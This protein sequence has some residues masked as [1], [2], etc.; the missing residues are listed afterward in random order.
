MN[1]LAKPPRERLRILI[2]GYIVR[3]PLGGM[4]WH[5]LQY[6]MSLHNLGHE[7]Y[8]LEDSDDTPFCCY[9]PM[10][11]VTDS[12]PTYGLKFAAD[13]LK[14][15]GLGD[16]WAYYDAHT[17][18]W[19]GPLA[20]GIL[21]LC[22]SADLLLNVSMANP[23]RPWLMEIPVRVAI[24]TDP[25][26][27]QIRNLTDPQRRERAQQHTAFFSFAE[28]INQPYSQIPDDG[29]PWQPTR[30]PI[31]LDAWPATP[32]PVGGKFTTVM[33]WDSYSTREY[34]G[35]RY[36]MKSA[37]FEPYL[38]LPLN[39]QATFELA[40]GSS[41]A[42][43][44]LL[45]QYGWQLSNPLEVTRTPWSYQHYLQASKAEFS[46]AKQ[47]YVI[48]NSG[49]FSERSACYLAS[50]RPVIV[51]DTGFSNVLPSGEGIMAFTTLEEAVAAIEDIESNY[52]K[53]AKAARAIAEAYF[54]ANKVLSK[55][56]N[57]AMNCRP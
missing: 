50:G 53:H 11:G 44:D 8:F 56:V 9:D 17:Q 42:P 37:S 6:A 36:G 22:A 14:Q 57:E 43:R 48:T 12:N 7:V 21:E 46:V 40:L 24:D 41:S 29:F 28:N 16:R 18:Q 23:L 39:T 31:V 34:N 32:A 47:G 38:E 52:T 26:F 27:F 2:L 30:Q 1:L 13:T 25:T 54:D 33:Q 15:V 20:D 3:C 5:H 10:R 49:W 4:A 35:V 51:Q 45:K 19:M 55:L